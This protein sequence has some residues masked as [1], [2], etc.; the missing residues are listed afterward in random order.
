[1]ELIDNT[2][3]YLGR[4]Q[5]TAGQGWFVDVFIEKQA[6]SSFFVGHETLR[7]ARPA[8]ESDKGPTI[9]AEPGYMYMLGLS[10][11]DAFWVHADTPG[12]LCGLEGA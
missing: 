1:M 12:Y 11:G 3:P 6:L 7:L 5:V 10:Q 2:D 9:T 8:T 4:R